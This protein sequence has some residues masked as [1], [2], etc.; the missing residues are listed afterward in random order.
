[1]SSDEGILRGGTP[2]LEQTCILKGRGGGGNNTLAS[3][4]AKV[5]AIEKIQRIIDRQKVRHS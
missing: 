4:S 5:L 2:V 1:M 3:F